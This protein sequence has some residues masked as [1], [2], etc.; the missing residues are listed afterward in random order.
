MWWQNTADNETGC[1]G[2]KDDNSWEKC[3]QA[4]KKD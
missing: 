4:V 3:G 1:L 2:V